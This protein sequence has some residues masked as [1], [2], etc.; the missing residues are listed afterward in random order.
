M[1]TSDRILLATYNLTRIQAAQDE[2]P[3]IL[4]SETCPVDNSAN[5][6]QYNIPV[7][8]TTLKCD[9]ELARVAVALNMA[10]FLRLWIVLIELCRTTGKLGFDRQQL[11]QTLTAHGVPHSEQQFNRWLRD[12]VGTFWQLHRNMVY[13]VGYEK[14]ATALYSKALQ[15][16]V[17]VNTVVTNTVGSRKPMY[18]HVASSNVQQFEANVFAAWVASRGN[19]KISWHVLERLWQHDHRT[20]RKWCKLSD[21]EIVNNY[22]F[23][24]A[25]YTH[26]I[27][28]DADGAERND[29]I[30]LTIQGV[31]YV[32]VNDSNSYHAPAIKQ[33]PARGQSSRVYSRMS[34]LVDSIQPVTKRRGDYTPKTDRLNRMTK[35]NYDTQDTAVRS[36]KRHGR[37]DMVL[38]LGAD[39]GNVGL[40]VYTPSGWTDL[41]FWQASAAVLHSIDKRHM[42]RHSM[43]VGVGEDHPF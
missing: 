13:P 40:W 32:R 39:D 3:V 31:E 9:D 12:G 24:R 20:I 8:D 27:P 22:Q 10:L 7:V 14:L 6:V 33:H 2:K 30:H 26:V 38:F 42:Y 21:V 4:P 1:N 34:Q 43:N 23:I 19:V 29:V 11:R 16:E 28:L 37:H 17:T 36:A 25:D 41:D 35:L 18:I 5:P 15:S